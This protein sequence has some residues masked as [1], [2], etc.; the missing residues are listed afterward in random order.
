[1]TLKCLPPELLFELVPFVPAENAVPDA[2]SSCRLFHCL[3]FKRVLNWKKVK[4][5]KKKILADMNID[6]LRRASLQKTSI[7]LGKLR[8]DVPAEGFHVFEAERNGLRLNLTNGTMSVPG[9]DKS[10]SL[11]ETVNLGVFDARSLIVRD[12]RN[13]RR[14]P[15]NEAIQQKMLDRFGQMEYRGR[16]LT[17]RDIAFRAETESPAATNGSKKIIQF[18]SDA[19]E[20]GGPP[21]GAE[22]ETRAYAFDLARIVFINLATNEHIPLELAIRSGQLPP[23]YLHVRDSLTG[24]EM[25]L[26]EAQKCGILIMHSGEDSNMSSYYLDKTTNMHYPLE[27][28][29][30]Q[31]HIYPTGGRLPE[32]SLDVLFISVRRMNSPQEVSL[33]E[34]LDLPPSPPELRIPL[35]FRMFSRRDQFDGT[36]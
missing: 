10:L 8:F 6:P 11:E 13:G 9:T 35:Y 36:R 33:R 29:A 14:L 16:R 3:L 5:D 34:L 4:E 26:D 31:G 32:N 24:R 19:A 30:R 20:T 21:M 18:P 23:D 17:L 2:I 1:M 25:S 15:L 27:E 22:Y 12:P 28:A 7:G